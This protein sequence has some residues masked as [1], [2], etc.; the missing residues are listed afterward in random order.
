ML[1]EVGL[2]ASTRGTQHNRVRQ[3]V[4]KW[5]HADKEGRLMLLGP[6][7]WV[8]ECVSVVSSCWSWNELGWTND[9]SE[10][11]LGGHFGSG[12]CT[13]HRWGGVWRTVGA[14]QGRSFALFLVRQQTVGHNFLQW[15]LSLSKIQK[16][17]VLPQETITF[18]T[19]CAIILMITLNFNRQWTSLPAV[20][21]H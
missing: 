8:P 16:F 11:I 5:H 12:M 15:A 3:F 17:I 2:E 13:W 6:N 21:L 4:P 19:F 9:P 18:H 7:S 10:R 14:G 20:V 1:P